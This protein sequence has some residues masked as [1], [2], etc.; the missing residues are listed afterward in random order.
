MSCFRLTAPGPS[1]EQAQLLR[2]SIEGRSQGVV[3]NP[4]QAKLL[5]L[6]HTPLCYWLSDRFLELVAGKKLG[7]I[8]GVHPGLQTSSDLR[9]VRFQ[10]EV[11]ERQVDV[12]HRRRWFHFEK[13]GGY[14]KWFGHH[15]GW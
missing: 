13:G 10:W 14:G 6:P 1:Y 4:V 15:S 12:P 5:N 8:A 3:F 7:D 2:D 9:F 11:G